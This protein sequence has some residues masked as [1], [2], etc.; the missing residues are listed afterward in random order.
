[1][2]DKDYPSESAFAFLEDMQEKFLQTF[3]KIDIEK[4]IPHALNVIFKNTLKERIE[5]FRNNRT[6]DSILKLKSCL[7]ETKNEI[8]QT[9]KFLTER[10]D[11]INIIAQKAHILKSDAISYNNWV[12][13][14][15]HNM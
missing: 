6:N 5:Y 15:I 2:R 10:S 8:L 12:S 9:D 7:F 14:N 11:K 1:M 4:A 13:H 3:S